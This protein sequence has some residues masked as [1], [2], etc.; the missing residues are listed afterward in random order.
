MAFGQINGEKEQWMEGWM[1]G[2][3]TNGEDTKICFI[4]KD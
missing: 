1:G 3:G 4:G 2:L